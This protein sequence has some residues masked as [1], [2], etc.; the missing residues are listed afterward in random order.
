MSD[1]T[2]GSTQ[3]TQSGSTKIDTTPKK[4]RRRFPWISI[5][6]FLVLIALGLF[7]GYQ[8]GLTVRGHAQ[9]TVEAQQLK[10]Q[11]DLG[12]QDLQAERYE[13]AYQRFEFIVNTDP[14]F[15]GVADKLA[16]VMLKMSITPSP[17]PSPTP[18]LTPTPDLRNADAIYADIQA[19]LQAQDWGGALAALDALRKN[20]PGYKVEEVDGMYY[21]A[22]RN[23]GVS[24]IAAQG[25]LEPGIYSLTL[26]ERFGPLDGYAEGLR[27]GARLYLTGASFWELD[28]LQTLNYFDQ[29]YRTW[30]GM[31]DAAS[32][33]T[34]TERYRLANIQV[35][36]LYYD[37]KEMC[38]AEGYYNTALSLSYDGDVA[39]KA[40]KAGLICHPPTSTPEPTQVST[41]A[42]PVAT[43][44]A[45]PSP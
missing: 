13:A 19:K 24:Q 22:L 16:E 39:Q 15:P 7:S 27:A 41:E 34:A 21:I 36:D 35:G 8:S 18:S 33:M 14:G 30:P 37:K 40:N 43:T 6:A 10:E 28:W 2:L 9:S 44:E 31:W 11:Y 1:E 4:P 26:A 12:V 3:P 29:V 17:T 45:P 5:L 42:P 23:Q 25:L 20:E 32:N 38:K